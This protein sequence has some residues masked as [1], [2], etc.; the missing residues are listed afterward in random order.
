MSRLQQWAAAAALALL[1]LPGLGLEGKKAD[2]WEVASP[3]NSGLLLTLTNSKRNYVMFLAGK[4]PEAAV[5][6]D[7]VEPPAT[8][9]EK[10]GIQ[11][12][13][14]LLASEKWPEAEAT[15]RDL[16]GKA[17][18]LHDA[19]ALLAMSLLRQKKPADA[20]TAL[21]ESLIGNRRNPEAWKALEETAAALGRK[22]LRP[23][24]QPRGWVLVQK[25]G[26]IQVGHADADRDCD[27]GW[28]F[29][30]VARASYR[31]EGSYAASC[32]GREYL[33]T[34][35]EQLFAAGAAVHWAEDARK[36][37]EKVADD[38]GRLL[39]EK[40]TKTL[41]PF[42]FFAMYPEPTP[43]E[44]EKDFDVLRP[45]LEKYFDEKILVKR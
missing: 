20:A 39:A 30:A 29:Y 33:F 23:V 40:K 44:P 12:C 21:R 1:A 9:E 31:Y 25:D 19:R 15:L 38:L 32:P 11:A 45:V 14:D 28:N 3:D 18:A 35:R 10:K 5:Q 43:A 22:V 7:R 2:P 36:D 27:F 13:R 42:V 17:P 37:G 6:P 8:D 41:V 16:L 34:F 24:L 4:V 26:D